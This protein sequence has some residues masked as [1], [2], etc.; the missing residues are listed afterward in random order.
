MW[1]EFEL[2]VAV[3]AQLILVP[4]NEPAKWNESSGD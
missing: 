2:T 3:A 4:H 1:T